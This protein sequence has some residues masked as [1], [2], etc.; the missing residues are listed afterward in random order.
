MFTIREVWL[1][2]L[3]NNFGESGEREH[4]INMECCAEVSYKSSM[5][6]KIPFIK[7]KVKKSRKKSFY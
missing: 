1:T 2:F 3:G 5:D 7:V 6:W 4:F